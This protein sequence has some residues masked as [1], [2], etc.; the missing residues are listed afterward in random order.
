VQEIA[1]ISAMLGEALEDSLVTG[2]SE[3]LDLFV[4]ASFG[5]LHFA[6]HNAFVATAPDSS[7]VMMG[8]SPFQPTFLNEHAQRF[9]DLSPLVFMNACRTDGQAPLYTRLDGWAIRFLAAGAGAFIGTLWEVTDK[10]AS[11]YAQEF[12]RTLMSGATLGDAARNGRES[13]RDR[14]GDPTW[15]AYS[16]YGDPAATL[17]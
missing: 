2:L 15:L 13:I 7:Q 12:Y 4:G 16:L 5:A 1:S 17:T 14:P 3:L 9:R 11:V 10:S 8:T 6:C